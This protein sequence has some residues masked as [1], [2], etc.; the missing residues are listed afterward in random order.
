MLVECQDGPTS[1][2]QK[3]P[4]AVILQLGI[5]LPLGASRGLE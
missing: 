1:S 2:L 3:T 4:A 5:F